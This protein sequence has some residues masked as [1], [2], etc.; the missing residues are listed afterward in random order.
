MRAWVAVLRWIIVKRLSGA[1]CA[2][3]LC[4]GQCCH[5]GFTC[6]GK[7]VCARGGCAVNASPWQSG[8]VMVLSINCEKKSFSFG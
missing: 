5:A 4:M 3:R 7:N 6:W 8:H 1:L 2:Q